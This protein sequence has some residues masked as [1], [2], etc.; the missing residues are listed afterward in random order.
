M[1]R[2]CSDITST[3]GRT[4]RTRSPEAVVAEIDHQCARYDARHVVF[5]DL[6]L[7]SDRT[8]WHGLIDGL[9][10]RKQGV[11]WIGAVHIDEDGSHALEPAT[12]RQAAQAGLVRLTTG[13]ESGS[14]RVLDLMKKG[15]QLAETSHVLRGA[16]A[17]GVSVRA[18][19]MVGY[20]GETARD[21]AATARFLED[22]REAIER[23]SINRFSL[24]TG[25][26]IDRMIE[27]K[28]ERFD[29]VRL[30]ARNDEQAIVDHVCLLAQG[31][32]FRRELRRVL[33]V[34]HQINRRP[35][36]PRARAFA[37]V[38]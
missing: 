18:T 2:F 23:V 30:L 12:I 31:R 15:T 38:M 14:Q 28:P 19:V 5:T 22:H 36:R 4:F 7:N 17:A 35:L 9:S 25:T 26:A 27:K 8:A 34:V 6:K 29:T 33:G 3:A 1:C 13:L 32:D 24:M 10:R 16:A 11:E 37:G 21:V 20:P